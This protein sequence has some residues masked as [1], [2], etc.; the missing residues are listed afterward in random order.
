MTGMQSGTAPAGRPAAA[1][2]GGPR[3]LPGQHGGTDG[4]DGAAHGAAD[5]G[6]VAA[7][8]R[9][10]RAPA[11][12]PVREG[13]PVIPP[14]AGPAVLTAALAVTAAAAAQWGQ[15][16]LLP[17]VLLL[18]A[19]TSAGWFRLN[20]MWPARQGIALAFA[21]GVTADAAV[22]AGGRDHADAALLGTLGVWFLLVIV[23]Q[24]RHRG[25]GE[26]RMDALTATAAATVLTVLAGSLLAAGQVAAEVVTFGALGVA[27][28]VLVRAAVP[29]RG[30]RAAR[31]WVGL[32]G[33]AAAVLAAAAVAQLA[34]R[35]AGHDLDHGLLLGAA[36]GCCAVLGLRVASYDWPSRFVHF[37]AGVA[38]PLTAAA[39]VLY[40]LARLLH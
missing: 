32:L 20:G 35:I 24:M 34:A 23:N 2:G 14:G 27:V 8:E 7:P 19:V 18:Q 40:G 22:L 13:S 6:G 11:R 39:P 5:G 37:T 29:D 16:A 26:E 3:L 33:P 17:A 10:S 1:D 38:L 4:A 9:P 36:A 30:G 12:G 25:S 31:A 21:A 28:A 15:A